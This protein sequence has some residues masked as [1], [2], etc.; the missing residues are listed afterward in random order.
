MFPT[1]S[2]PEE[3]LPP[4]P[5]KPCVGGNPCPEVIHSGC[6]VYDGASVP[7]LNVQR[8]ERLG[9]VLPKLIEAICSD[10]R[11][12][13]VV[14]A[15]SDTISFS[16]H[17][18]VNSPLK[19]EVNI[20]ALLT[21]ILNDANLR[22]VFCQIT[23]ACGGV[24]LPANLP[25]LVS[26]GPDRTLTL[27]VSSL[28]LTGTA[29][30]SD[31]VI[32]STIWTQVSGPNTAFIIFGTTLTPTVSGLVAGTYVF[33]L[34]ATDDKGASSDDTMTVVVSPAAGTGAT[35]CDTPTLLRVLS[36]TY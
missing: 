9:T 36:T 7:C 31:G 2:C 16:G 10:T 22:S 15:N 28:A 27:P 14:V 8:G 13:S 34:E 18:T 29:S 19:A 4:T 26:A 24:S 32:V 1:N 5:P 12:T 23:A 35:S 6:V 30:D 21:K 17:G 20:A 3:G 33:R 11:T 25:P